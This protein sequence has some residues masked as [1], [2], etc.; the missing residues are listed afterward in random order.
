MKTNIQ[1]PNSK[2]VTEVNIVAN[3]EKRKAAFA[4]FNREVNFKNVAV[5]QEKIQ[6][7]GYRVGEPIQVLKAEYAAEQITS[8]L[9]NIN[10]KPIAKDEI[11]N[12]FLVVDG[13]HRTFAVSQYNDWAKE[14]NRE[15]INIP[16]IEV[17]LIKG[18]TV[19][20]YCN[21]INCT[22]KEWSKEDYINGAAS[23]Q[24]DEELLQRYN[25]LI[26]SESNPKGFSLST[27]NHIFCNGN[28]LTKKDLILLCSGET[29][30]GT[31]ARKE[32]IPAHN[33]EIGNKFIEICKSKG[34][35]Q[36]E[37]SK[38]Y[39]IVEFNKIRNSQNNEVAV[40]V[41]NSITYDDIS[42]MSKENGKLDEQQV[43][44]H[45]KLM[46]ERLQ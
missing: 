40:K 13:H 34:V 29:H 7:K 25:E 41:L 31:I 28:G 35:K 24:P 26:K 3:N 39:L 22:K 36:S 18:E 9:Q 21:E 46:I 10:G 17:E 45:F 11:E 8:S 27:L 2:L 30:K 42:T 38:R 12:Y 14:H 4:S 44:D 20:E 16:A 37:I 32:I 23:V 1:N 6:E 5:I 33:L 19:T 43:I 15:P